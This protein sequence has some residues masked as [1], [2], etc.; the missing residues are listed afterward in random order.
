MSLSTDFREIRRVSTPWVVVQTSDYRATTKEM[1]KVRINGEDEPDA[2]LWTCVNG[3]CRVQ[4]N[5]RD[6]FN[7]GDADSTPAMVLGLALDLPANSILFLVVPDDFASPNHFWSNPFTTQAVANLRD[8]FKADHR[9]LV[10]L[11]IDGKMPALVADDVPVL[12]DPLPTL[13]DLKGIATNLA[14][15]V[16]VDVGAEA[17]GKGAQLCLGMTRFSAEESVARKL[18]RKGGLDLE[19]LAT[20]Q[21]EQIEKASERGLAFESSKETFDSIGGLSQ[22]KKFMGRIFNGTKRPTVIVRLEEIEKAMAGIS[23]GGRQGDTSGVSDDQLGVLLTAM[24]DNGWTGLMAPG[25]A[26]TGKSLISKATANTYGVPSINMDLGAAK[27]SYVGQSEGRIRKLVSILK[28]FAGNGAFFIATSNN[29]DAIPPALQRRF[30]AGTWFFDL[31]TAEERQSIWK[32]NLKR[33]ELD[34]KQAKPDDN[35]F[36]GSDI[37]NICELAAS[38]C[39]PILEASEYIIPVAKS[40]PESITRLREAASGKYLSASQPGAYR[41]PDGVKEGRAMVI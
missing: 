21:R 31:P 32:I 36:T 3:A 41:K 30:K 28:S 9:T 17:I 25:H 11:S 6:S 10:V 14:E 37:R 33:F 22:I 8:Q 40:N 29:I 7:L 19:G 18:T 2:F 23:G 27:G 16:K 5:E 39:C 24:E 4:G 13:D 15:S 26:G 1:L 35:D 38:L 20:A 34:A 12:R